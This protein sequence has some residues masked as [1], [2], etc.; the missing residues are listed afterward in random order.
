MRKNAPNLRPNC[1]WITK[2]MLVRA[3]GVEPVRP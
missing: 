1:L 3:T 2:A